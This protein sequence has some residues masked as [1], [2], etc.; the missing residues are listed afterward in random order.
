[1]LNNDV[2]CEGIHVLEG[3]EGSELFAVFNLVFGNS[4][5]GMHDIYNKFKYR[6]LYH[7]FNK[8]VETKVRSGYMA[9][10]QSGLYNMNLPFQ[11]SP[12]LNL[13]LVCCF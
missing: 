11:I 13:Y 4:G 3:G 7:K 5:A 12:L 2:F 10:S 9:S 8:I 6:H 1:M